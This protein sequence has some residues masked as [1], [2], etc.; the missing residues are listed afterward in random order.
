[1]KEREREAG[2][3][4]GKIIPRIDIISGKSA[5]QLLKAVPRLLCANAELAHQ[6]IRFFCDGRRSIAVLVISP[7]QGGISKLELHRHSSVP[8]NAAG[9]FAVLLAATLWTYGLEMYRVAQA[10]DRT[11]MALGPATFGAN[12]RRVAWRRHS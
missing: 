2:Q 12:M 3:C 4:I 6:S 5:D 7:G 8:L 10:T 9:R 1:V 11:A